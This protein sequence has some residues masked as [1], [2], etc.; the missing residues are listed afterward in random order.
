ML[1][2][3]SLPP[4]SG[5]S[6]KRYNLERSYLLVGSGLATRPR[7]ATAESSATILGCEWKNRKQLPAPLVFPRHAVLSRPL[8]AWSA[9]SRPARHPPSAAYL[10]FQARCCIM[11]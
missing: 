2:S 6:R 5:R 7:Q 4:R 11:A 10:T 8:P 3:L 9:R 1:A